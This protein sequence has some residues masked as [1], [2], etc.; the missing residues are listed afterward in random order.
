MQPYYSDDRAT[1]YRGNALAVLANIP[2]ATVD[3]VIT[4]PPYSSG[5]MMRGDRAEDTRL[6]YT[7]LKQKHEP[8]MHFAGDTRDGRG[9]AYW[10]TLW[11]AEA[12]RVTRVGG[13]LVMFSDWRQLPAATDALQAGGWIWRGIVPWIKP[14]ARPQRG[15]FV[16]SAEFVAWGTAGPRPPEGSAFPGYYLARVPRATDPEGRHHITQKPF[17]VMR[18][19]VRIAP[20]DGVVLDPFMGSGTTG[21]AALLEG[22]RFV[23][24]EITDH[25]AGVAEQRIRETLGLASRGDQDALPF[26]DNTD[27]SG[28]AA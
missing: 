23:G 5:G 13:V 6:K 26:G 4:D 14:N 28:G 21:A 25:Y 19:L 18:S 3:A 2:T 12:L 24:V 11:L 10:M 1:L 16:Q 15:R 7:G 22:K 20:P 27:R 9:W 8:A 17:E